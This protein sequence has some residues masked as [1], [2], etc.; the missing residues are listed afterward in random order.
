MTPSTTLPAATY[1]LCK[2]IQHALAMKHDRFNAI[3]LRNNQKELTAVINKAC[4]KTFLSKLYKHQK[5]TSLWINGRDVLCEQAYCQ[6]KNLI[7]IP[8]MGHGY[9]LGNG[10][11]KFPNGL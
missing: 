7:P 1:K 6:L 9:E 3:I 4:Y 10:C 8:P 5:T 11:K 2:K